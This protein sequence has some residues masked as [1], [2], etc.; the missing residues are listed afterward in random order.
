VSG[1]T[2]DVITNAMAG[3]AFHSAVNVQECE[4]YKQRT[5][6]GGCRNFY[7]RE[8]GRPEFAVWWKCPA[9]H[10]EEFLYCAAHGPEHLDMAVRGARTRCL[11][12]CGEWMTPLIEG[13]TAEDV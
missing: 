13:L 12:P 10:R 5:A 3:L 11:P 1:E 4:H 8:Q 9:G 2:L 7:C 6:A